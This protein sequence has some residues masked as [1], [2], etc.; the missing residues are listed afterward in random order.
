MSK[1][2]QEWKDILDKTPSY[3]AESAAGSIGCLAQKLIRER[4][5]ALEEVVRLRT[6]LEGLTAH[7]NEERFDTYDDDWMRGH[8]RGLQGAGLE[9]S[10]ILEGD[11][12]D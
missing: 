7:I 2:T 9:I 5:E 1:T 4:E 8:I 6:R 10:H 12:D 3:A 11:S